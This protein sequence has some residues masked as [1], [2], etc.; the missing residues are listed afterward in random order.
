VTSWAGRPYLTGTE[1][2]ALKLA[3]AVL[4]NPSGE[5]VD[6]E[7]CARPSAHYNHEALWTL[8]LA[9]G[10][11]CFSIPLLSLAIRSPARADLVYLCTVIIGIEHPL[12]RA[13]SAGRVW[14]VLPAR[15]P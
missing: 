8:T 7:P 1:R 10:Q 2:A 11:M 15:L 3:E 13:A 4:T 14:I 6:D 5:R 12:S 9:I